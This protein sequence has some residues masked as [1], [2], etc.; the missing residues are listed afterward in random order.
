MCV[1]VCVR[2]NVICV[3]V[4]VGMETRGQPQASFLKCN[5]PV[6]QDLPL[7]AKQATEHVQTYLDCYMGSRDQIYVLMIASQALN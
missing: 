4:Q 3:Y 2:M 1:Y 6:R 7:D 5:L